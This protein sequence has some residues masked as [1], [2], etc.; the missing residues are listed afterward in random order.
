M[1]QAA[2]T[3]R[4]PSTPPQPRRPRLRELGIYRLPD[5]REFVVSTLFHDGCSLYTPHAWAT[6]GLPE[7]WV[8]SE[9]RLLRTGDP[10]GWRAQDLTDTG[11]TT[12]YP[13]PVLL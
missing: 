3:L 9:G 12:D 2:S 8:D 4:S 13:K 1:A 7:Y 11:K 10:T 5:G 6:F